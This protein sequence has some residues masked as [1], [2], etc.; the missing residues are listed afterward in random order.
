MI[1]NFLR[2]SVNVFYVFGCVVFSAFMPLILIVYVIYIIVE[3][4]RLDGFRMWYRGVSEEIIFL[5]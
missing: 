1:L 3:D 4:I 2:L 5:R